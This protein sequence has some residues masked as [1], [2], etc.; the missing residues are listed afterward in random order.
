MRQNGVFSLRIAHIALSLY[1]CTKGISFGWSQKGL[2]A[3][4]SFVHAAESAS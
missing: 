2:N 1:F 4:G 3:F